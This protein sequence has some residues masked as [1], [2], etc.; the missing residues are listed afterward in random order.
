MI[1]HYIVKHA[2]TLAIQ[3]ARAHD[4]SL[5]ILSVTGGVPRFAG[6]IGEVDEYIRGRADA[7]RAEQKRALG[8]ESEM[9]GTSARAII[10]VGHAGHVI[11]A[12]AE[13]EYADLLLLGRSR[14]SA[15]RGR[16][17]GSTLV[18][19]AHHAPCAVLIAR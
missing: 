6:T 10:Q 9:G 17:V 3:L 7:L 14:H 2:L 15:V 13:R 18:D 19:V 16:C 12:V 8:L 1:V 5:L 11:V 4:A